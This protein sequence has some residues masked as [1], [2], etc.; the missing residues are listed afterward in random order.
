[1]RL[2][3]RCLAVT[4]ILSTPVWAQPGAGEQIK[5]EGQVVQDLSGYG[6]KLKRMH[7]GQ[8]VTEGLHELPRADI[9]TL[10]W[11]PAHVPGD[12]YTDL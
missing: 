2:L 8:G 6:W 10:L 12:V 3:P 11:M 4:S 5:S 7:P 9:E 1:M